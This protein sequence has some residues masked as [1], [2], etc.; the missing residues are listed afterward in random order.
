MAQEPDTKAGASN[1]PTGPANATST[2]GTSQLTL[3]LNQTAPP[4]PGVAFAIDNPF[5]SL[6]NLPGAIAIQGTATGGIGVQ[7]QSGDTTNASAGVY[8]ISTGNGPGVYGS[9]KAN[10]AVQGV[11][12]STANAGVA[13]HNTS[14]GGV[15]VYGTGGQ[16]AGKFDGNLLVNGNGA[17]T[18]VNVNGT[19]TMTGLEVLGT[20]SVLVDLGVS[21]NHTVGGSVSVK[22]NHAVGGNVTVTGDVVLSGA[23]C[24]EEFDI[25]VHGIEPGTVM[26]LDENGLLR[27]SERAYDKRVAGVVSGAGDYRPAMILDRRE[28]SQQR[29]PIALVGKAFCK[30]DAQ[31]GQIE[32]GDLLTTST[33]PG[34]AM[35]ASD[36]TKAFGA[37]I[38]KALQPLD[39]GCGLIPILVALQ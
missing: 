4:T 6:P 33:T 17:F 2:S 34:H 38:G 25:G 21:G 14:T 27:P 10:D 5:P 3:P 13:G 11:S 19:S 37:V 16:Y 1:L 39:S 18:T 28:S 8:G 9:A 12:S 31:Y 35:R 36:A 23:D 22:G 7:G 20:A 26:V 30:A 32:I 24:A 15:G 29:M